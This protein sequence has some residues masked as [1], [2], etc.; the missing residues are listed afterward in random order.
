[1]EGTSTLPEGWP[2]LTLGW[3]VLTWA[4]K[5]LTQPDGPHEGES[6]T[7]TDDQTK[8]V[9]WFYEVDSAGRFTYQHASLR[10]VKGAGK[11][12]FAAVLALAELC[13]PVRFSHFDANGEPVGKPD[14]LPRVQIAATAASQTANTMIMVRAMAAKGSRLVRAHGLDVGKTIFYTPSGGQLETLTSSPGTAEGSLATFAVLDETEHWLPSPTMGGPALARAIRRNLAKMPGH[15]AVETSNAFEPGRGSVAELTYNSWVAQSEGR[16]KD[17]AA[18]TL[19]HAR[20]APIDTNLDDEVSLDR[21]LEFVYRHCP[22]TDRASIKAAIWDTASP[23][24][25]SLRFYLNIPTVSV[26]TWVEPA[27]W[28][29]LAAPD[30][31]VHDGDEIALFFDGSKSND[32]TALVGCRLSDGHVFTLGVWEPNELRPLVPVAEVDLTVRKAHERYCVRGFFG[33][34]AEWESFVKVSWPNDLD[35]TYTAQAVPGGKEPQAIAWDM[36]GHKFDFAQACEFAREEIL[37]GQFTHDGD[38][39]V[40]RHM[41]NARFRAVG[42]YW[43]ISKE[44]AKSP[45]KIDAAVCVIGARMVRRLVLAAKPKDKPHDGRVVFM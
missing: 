3:G 33:D 42:A 24:A 1:M 45:L 8:F 29:K 5:Y 2:A 37:A 13:G 20:I 21:A 22:W 34:V 16:T 27:L 19:Y 38:P 7:P 32:A 18:R 26:E 11:S 44:A 41:A 17:G 10:L 14:P 6:W 35:S 9:A 39:R 31:V 12:P 43:G 28:A 23:Q 15:R 4:T 30:V 25:E 40:A 36:R